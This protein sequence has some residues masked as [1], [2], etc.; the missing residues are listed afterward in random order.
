MKPALTFLTALLAAPLAAGPAADWQSDWRHTT[1]GG[2]YAERRGGFVT[3]GN[4]HLERVFRVSEDAVRTTKLLNKV[5]GQDAGSMEGSEFTLELAGTPP[6]EVST[7]DFRI[8]GIQVDP[9]ANGLRLV[10]HLHSRGEEGLLVDLV[11]EAYA[12]RKYQRRWLAI[13]Q[14][15]DRP[16]LTIQR[17]DVEMFRFGWWYMG[18]PVLS[19][20]GQP[21]FAGDVYLGLEYPGAETGPNY[22]R[23][24]PGR[25]ARSRF[26]SKTA[27][28][29][30]AP[31]KDRVR[32]AFFD[33]YLAT[34]PAVRPKPFVKYSLIGVT[35]PNT[36]GRPDEKTFLHWLPI[37]AEACRKAGLPVDSYATDSEWEDYTSVWKPNPL[38]FPR[39]FREL[40]AFA[41][42]HGA[43]FG[44]WLSLAGHTLDTR[45]GKLHGLEVAR[46]GDK[47]GGGKYCLA[48]PRYA[49]ELKRTLRDYILRDRVNHFKFDYNSFGCDD[50][51]HGHPVGR[52][53]KDAQLDA[54]IELLKYF[55]EVSPDVHFAITSGMWLS[56]WWTLYADWVWLGGND[57]GWPE[58]V[59]SLSPYE[60]RI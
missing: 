59:K 52:P 41:Q 2:V 8:T 43:G 47:V 50:A 4:R 25:S 12:D 22:L 54:Y 28:W 14:E 3:L 53:G 5:S 58:K 40:A 35:N 34:L 31:G 27:I 10:F 15:P 24:Y 60:D 18:N 57:L 56:P 1:A 30:A 32:Q 39:G 19:G 55:R 46:I 44:L 7:S 36:A 48:G 38:S 26:E 6:R 49:A 13:A 51:S 37:M 29:G 33:D 20:Y 9:L 11:Q 23:H 17:I 42:Q 16:E 21:V 45:W